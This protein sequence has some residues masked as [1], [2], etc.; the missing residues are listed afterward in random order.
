MRDH[1]HYRVD[2]LAIAAEGV[3]QIGGQGSYTSM[4]VRRGDLQYPEVKISAD[5]LVPN[6]DPWL[7]RSNKKKIYIS[8]DEKDKTFFKAF[9]DKGHEVVFWRDL[10]ISKNKRVPFHWE[11]MME[12][13]VASQSNLFIGTRLST[14]S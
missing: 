5:R 4:H 7:T 10:D 3:D 1:V 11:G 13:L 2:M 9:T 6:I 12:Q 14:F 8:T